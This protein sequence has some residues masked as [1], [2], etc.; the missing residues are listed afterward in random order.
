MYKGFSILV[1][2]G[3][4]DHGLWHVSGIVIRH[5][6]TQIHMILPRYTE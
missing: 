6:D 2:V 3:S 5:S 1:L 4:G